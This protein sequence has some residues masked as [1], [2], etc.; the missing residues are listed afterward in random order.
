MKVSFPTTNTQPVIQEAEVDS[1]PE[2]AATAPAPAP[3]PAIDPAQYA[4]FLAFQQSQQAAAPA[5]AQPIPTPTPVPTPAPLAVV[6]SAPQSLAVATSYSDVAGAIDRSDFKLPYC[7]IVAFISKL[8]TEFPAGT[9]LLEDQLVLAEPKQPL[10]CVAAFV[11]KGYVENIPYESEVRARRY[12]SLEEVKATG[13]TLSYAKGQNNFSEYGQI[14]FLFPLQ[15]GRVLNPTEELFFTWDI[16]GVKH[17]RAIW[18][19]QS[20]SYDIVR[21]VLTARKQQLVNCGLLGGKFSISSQLFSGKKS[22]YWG[23]TIKLSGYNTPDY[24]RAAT[25]LLS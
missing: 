25:E 18:T 15:E 11:K 3:A 7:K 2:F 24:I 21:K 17:A 6:P 14:E 16:L 5:P 22:Q 13:G 4:A 12:E 9:V 19:F 10:E 20:T 8:V 23:P 1:F